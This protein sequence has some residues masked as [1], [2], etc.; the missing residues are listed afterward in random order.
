MP[1]LRLRGL[2]PA[3]VQKLSETLADELATI[4]ETAPDNFTVE[5]VPSQFF[6]KG[7]PHE[8]YPFVE[9]LWFERAQAVKKKVAERI[10]DCVR[11]LSKAP[12]VAVVF[13]NL[14]RDSYFEN[15]KHF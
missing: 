10:T 6:A 9:V 14:P 2:Q 7:L 11:S 3:L 13:R 4:L 5:Y 8:G 12:D 1:H 15:G